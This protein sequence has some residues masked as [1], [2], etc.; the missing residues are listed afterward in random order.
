MTTP[1]TI[2]AA[3]IAGHMLCIGAQFDPDRLQWPRGA[4]IALPHMFRATAIAALDPPKPFKS[5]LDV[6]GS[7]D[8][9]PP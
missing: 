4:V 8:E 5:E 9:G 6:I 3:R 2:I 7:P 1:L